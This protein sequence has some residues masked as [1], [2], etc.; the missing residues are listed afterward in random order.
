MLPQKGGRRVPE[1]ETETAPASLLE[2]HFELS[3][4]KTSLRTEILAGFTTFL[5]MAYIVLV[6]PAILGQA[7][8]P[9]AAVAAATCLAAGASASPSCSRCTCPGRWLWAASSSRESPSCC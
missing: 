6:N 1:A 2:R 8:M 9:V 4:R 5:T 3:A 7:G